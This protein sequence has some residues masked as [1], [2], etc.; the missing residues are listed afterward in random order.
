MMKIRKIR[1]I[2]KF[3]KNALASIAIYSTSLSAL[4]VIQAE[5]YV[6]PQ[7]DDANL[8]TLA[9][10][11]KTITKAREEIRL[12]NGS[13]TGDIM[14]YLQQGDYFTD[15]T[16][17]FNDTDSGTNGYNVIYKNYDALG[18]ARIIGGQ[19]LSGWELYSGN[20]YRT[21]VGPTWE[22]DTLY[23][24]GKR[25]TMARHPNTGYLSVESEDPGA[26]KQAF[27]HKPS[28]MPVISDISGL[29]A[30]I[31][32]GAHDWANEILP[33]I[34]IAPDRLIT[35]SEPQRY[36]YLGDLVADSRYFVQGAYDLIDQPGEY[37]LDKT[38]DYLY[39]YPVNADIANQ[40]IIAPKVETIVEFR[41]SS[42]S[43]LA[44]NIQLDGLTVMV[45][46]STPASFNS[47]SIGNIT[48]TR[49]QN[50][51]V[52]NSRITNSASNGI[53]MY[54]TTKTA[55]MSEA[56]IYGNYIS[57]VGA[58]GV[59]VQG[60]GNT[61]FYRNNNHLIQNNQIS[62]IARISGNGGGVMLNFVANSE[63]SYNRIIDASHY[64][65]QVKGS[66]WQLMPAEIDGIPVTTA[67]R[68]D[69]NPGRYN[70]VKFN[71]VSIC[72][73]DTQDTG[74]L[75]SGGTYQ[76]TFDN[77][78]LYDSGS[79][80]GIQKGIY[81][82]DVSDYS[83]VSNNI[84]YGIATNDVKNAALN[85][86]GISNNISNNVFDYDG[87]GIRLMEFN[88]QETSANNLNGNIFYSDASDIM[89]DFVNPNFTTA[90]V[91]TSDNNVFYSS[92]SGAR[93][94]L[95]ITPGEDTLAN[96]QTL[97]GASY[98]QNSSVDDPLFVDAAAHDY[99]LQAGSPALALGFV[100][101][102]QATIGLKADYAYELYVPG[103]TPP[104]SPPPL[105]ASFSDDFESGF[106]NWTISLRGTATAS[107][108]QAHLGTSS[109][110]M[111]E[112]QDQI[113]HNMAGD[114]NGIVTVWFYD[115]A[116]DTSMKVRATLKDALN[117]KIQ[118]GVATYLST[119]NYAYSVSGATYVS[120]SVARS[121]GW[122]EFKFDLT[123]GT[124]AKLYIDGV[125]IST[126]TNVT[127]FKTIVLGDSDLDGKSGLVYFDNLYVVEVTPPPPVAP[128]FEDD[129]ESGFAN[130]STSL[131]GTATTSVVQGQ[132][133]TFSYEMDEDQ[134]QIGHNMA[135]D[136]NGVVSVWF[137]D[138][139]NE[140]NM[141]VRTTLKNALGTKIQIGVV[142]YESATNYSYSIVGTTYVTSSVARTTGWHEFKF[143]LTSGTDAKLYIDKVW[144]ATTTN[145]TD[146]KTI[147]LGD[148][149]NDGR[150]G[151]VYFDNVTVFE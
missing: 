31:W 81:L 108:A 32:P 51:A 102:D 72:N 80:F 125:L 92:L 21:Y 145:V 68:Y 27:Y 56:Y 65:V 11:L 59:V 15:T 14:V 10:P 64:G 58:S 150:S 109:Y 60:K 35:L 115:D 9:S 8:G 54:M 5:L 117:T 23:E 40:E 1:K 83:T 142:T 52:K 104:P 93:S 76:N 61:K 53:A 26:P 43:L 2:T 126:T 7:G 4:A 129:F 141:K 71:D 88:G 12:I 79:G 55:P 103:Q 30:Y 63:V 70:V 47:A 148:S 143:D 107:T 66:K 46:D 18:S 99:S 62:D 13:M 120:S 24:N 123:S 44:H 139:T 112:D 85:V 91:A 96:W 140:T 116:A 100:A 77:N 128:I 132:S 6:S 94:F 69:F 119:T 34:S 73:L 3:I 98:D 110:V 28:D 17:T 138:D 124:D 41:G 36:P 101:I 22:F 89:Y 121:T 111:D 37:Y 146:V 67:N 147:V 131:Q 113:G 84:V 135:A 74:I 87:T 106:T 144:I 19:K 45:S 105:P 42:D 133:G 134:D 16:I 137:Y 95:K 82:D 48:M 136:T 75:K 25:S 151:T 86:K 114:T 57:E 29:Q 90:L 130:W 97:N 39:Y 118:I 49:A 122:H 20:I 78:K 50:I 33:I 149:A 38:T 127:D